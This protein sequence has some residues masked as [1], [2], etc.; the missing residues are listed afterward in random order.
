MFIIILFRK[1]SEE[2]D[3][4]T[5]NENLMKRTNA[6]NHLDPSSN[7]DEDFECNFVN[8]LNSEEETQIFKVVKLQIC[9]LKVILLVPI[10]TILTAGIAL[11]FIIW[12]VDV[13]YYLVFWRVKELDKASFLLVYGCRKQ[14]E[15]V[16]IKRGISIF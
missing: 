7:N 15:I 12:Y 5:E 13:M 10:L 2:K 9:W 1:Y 8:K 4:A 6:G 14:K 11:L 3:A 16:Y